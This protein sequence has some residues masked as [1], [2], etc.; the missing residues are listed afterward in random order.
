M[1][2]V[3]YGLVMPHGSIDLT[4]PY[5]YLNQSCFSLLRLC[6][7]HLRGISLGATVLYNVFDNDTF[8][9]AATSAGCNELTQWVIA[10]VVL[11]RLGTWWRHQM[12]NFST[13]LVICAGNSSVNGEFPAQR[14]VTRSFDF[15]LICAWMN[16]WVN[17]GDLRCHRSHYDVTVS[18]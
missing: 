15:S 16:G 14:P 5:H 8:N 3:H 13:L 12:E 4:A 11:C 10:C 9:I 6:G 7:I 1:M 17:S 2:A 18:L